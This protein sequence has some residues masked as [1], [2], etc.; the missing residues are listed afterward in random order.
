M[1]LNPFTQK[2]SIQMP[3][4]MNPEI[5]KAI[6]SSDPST[7]PDD[8]VLVASF[9]CSYYELAFIRAGGDSWNLATIFDDEAFPFSVNRE[10]AD[11]LQWIV[12]Y[13]GYSKWACG[14]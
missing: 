1:L 14:N 10:P 8:F 13:S 4:L 9:Y 6:L 3:G 11:L 2:S 5:R 7:C 12:V